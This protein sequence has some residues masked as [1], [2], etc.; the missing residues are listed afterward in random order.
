MRRFI[1]VLAAFF[2]FSVVL[3]GC[4]SRTISSGSTE[5]MITIGITQIVEHPALDSAREGFIK[6]L[7]DNGYVEGK[8]VTF[9]QENAQGDMSTAQTIAKKFVDKNV[10]LIFSIATPTTQAVKKATST[11]P[12]V[13]TAVTDPV[14]AGLVKSFDKPGGNVTGTSDMEPINDQLKLI[15]DLVPGAKRIGIIYNAGEVNS[16]VQVKIAKDDAASLGYSIVEATVSNSSE[17]NQAAQSLVG[18]VDAI[19]L[20]TDNTVASSVAAIIKVANSAKIPVVAAEKGMV[21]G[22]SLATLGI[23][24]SDLGYQA[25]SM[26]IKILKGEKPANIK[27]ETAKNLQL[28]INQKEADAIGLKIPDSIMKKAQ[29]VIK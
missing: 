12:I 7:K 6:A 3:S 18:K 11:I 2:I 20:P 4:G 27:V 5:K 10:D 29:E 9:I 23:S 13:F 25:G 15:K 14:A 26:A 28:I 1:F 17:V 24:Y 19:W 21:E 22:G 8:N 16:T